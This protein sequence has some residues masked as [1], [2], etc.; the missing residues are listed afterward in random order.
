MNNI[1]DALRTL[2]ACHPDHNECVSLLAGL[3]SCFKH[4]ENPLGSDCVAAVVDL[5]DQ[6][7]MEVE[8]DKA[9]QAE[10][11]QWRSHEKRTT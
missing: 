8:N 4:S 9:E 10:E 11:Q 5:L 6:A 3:A 2:R 1:D 7:A